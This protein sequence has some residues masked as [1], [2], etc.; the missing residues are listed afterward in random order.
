MTTCYRQILA[1]VGEGWLY[2]KKKVQTYFF[3]GL[4]NELRGI[5]A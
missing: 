1:I 5:T 4:L 3:G 2:E